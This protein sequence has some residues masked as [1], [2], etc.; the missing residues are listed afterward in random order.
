MPQD[1]ALRST[2]SAPE[3]ESRVSSTRRD[4]LTPV[5]DQLRAERERRGVTLAEVAEATKIRRP[6]LQALERHDWDDLPA[7]VFARGFLRSYAE[8]LTLDSEH[9]L[10]VYERQRR[11]THAADPSAADRD[12]SDARAILE[13][14]AR[15]RGIDMRSRWR[16]LIWNGIVIAG[17][18]VA[19][20]VVWTLLA[21]P[22]PGSADGPASAARMSPPAA[23]AISDAPMALGGR[24]DP[25]PVEA[26]D[27]RPVTKE[28][29]SLAEPWQP[30]AV[31]AT[32]VPPESASGRDPA[33]VRAPEPGHL[34]VS[35]FDIG[36][37]VAEARLAGGPHRFEEGSVL[38]FRASVLG[39]RPGDTIRHVWRHGA[40]PV[41]VAPIDLHGETWSTESRLQLL[42]GSI[43]DWTVE[44]RDPVGRVLARVR[45]T[46][47][48]T[49][50]VAQDR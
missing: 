49:A 26:L 16:W 2:G 24:T 21:R 25:L 33:P 18:A 45:F 27:V 34:T 39:G 7:P 35:E 48:T 28:A 9:L 29:T 20:A 37:E 41:A 4:V 42:P 30:P 6:Y 38:W 14:I 17:T 44:A 5:G 22:A 47:V 10:R 19:A 36:T 46:C 15:A 12:E 43:G 40:R 31:E 3:V 8:H 13:Q 23:S 1:K 32:V 11:L 50:G